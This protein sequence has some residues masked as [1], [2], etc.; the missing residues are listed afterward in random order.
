MPNCNKNNNNEEKV[1]K[2]TKETVKQVEN[3]GLPKLVAQVF[4]TSSTA[5]AIE[6]KYYK[7]TKNSCEKIIK[8]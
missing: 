2:I 7:A 4:H 6:P 1:K 5:I 3:C 8:I